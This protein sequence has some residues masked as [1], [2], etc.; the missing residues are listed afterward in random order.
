MGCSSSSEDTVKPPLPKP[1][2]PIGKTDLL[3]GSVAVGV[4]S[5][6][7]QLRIMPS[8]IHTDSRDAAPPPYEDNDVKVA[9]GTAIFKDFATKFGIK[10]DFL[11]KLRALGNFKIKILCDDSRSMGDNAYTAEFVTDPFGEIPT[12]F[13]ELKKMVKNVIDM[14]GVLSKEGVDLY[15]LN[16]AGRY[17]VKNYA[18]VELLFS[19]EPAGLTPTVKAIKQIIT[20]TSMIMGEK[21][22]LLFLPTDGEATDESGTV[23]IPEMD[24]YMQ[25]LNDSYPKL[26]ITFMACISDEKLL[27]TMDRWGKRYERVGVVDEFNVEHKE[28]MEKHGSEPGFDFTLGDYITK[29]LLVSIDPVIKSL[30]KDNDDDDAGDKDKEE[31]EPA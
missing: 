21:N 6:G 31:I 18:E 9:K 5:T 2:A 24:A 27:K 14:A 30:F 16:R 3:V 13:Q 12:R 4:D 22:V 15:F 8:T 1:S 28:M 10:D 25:Y 7:T 11:A 23:N 17:N 29:S 26:Y 19:A 20:D